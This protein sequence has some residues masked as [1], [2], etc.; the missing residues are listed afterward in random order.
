VVFVAIDQNPNTSTVKENIMKLKVGD[1]VR[2]L[3][4]IKEYGI[5][6]KV[7]EYDNLTVDWRI[8]LTY[9]GTI[10]SQWRGPMI[11]EFELEEFLESLWRYKV[12]Q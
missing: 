1:L 4:F 7:D 12:F 9:Q 10:K 5:I 8:G 2:D 3:N 11:D 6:T